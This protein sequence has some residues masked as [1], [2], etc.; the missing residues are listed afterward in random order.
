ME[1]IISGI[2]QMGIGIPNVEEAWAWYRENFMFDV[3]VFDDAGI[4]DLM[5]PYTGN[6]PHERRAILALNLQGGGGFEIWQYVSRK[7]EAPKFQVQLGDYGI[8]IAKIKT[9]NASAAFLKMKAKKLNLLSELV[10]DPGGNNTF[11]VSDPY[12]N[13]FQ[14]VENKNLFVDTKEVN[15][16]VFGAVLGVADIEKSKAFYKEILGYDQLVFETEGQFA[17]FAQIDG[18]K[19]QF[20]RV[21]LRHSKAR[22]GAFAE[23]LGPSE[24]ELLEVTNR[25]AQKIYKERF[26]GDLGYIHLCYDIYG[27]Q[28][29]KKKCEDFG[30]PFTVDSAD[31]FDMGE[32][33]GHFTYIEDPDG[34]LIEF[35]ETHK[36]P[37]VKKMKINLNLNRFN[38]SKSLPKWMLKLAFKRSK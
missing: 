29:L 11:Y 31:S 26:W 37:I 35:V 16:G 12:G 25:K 4:A 22:Q 30:Q 2:Q 14:F 36:I 21:L 19:H 5:L 8:A 15:G 3:K 13:V 38:R 9:S 24:I 28:A 34:T 7:P 20:K 33:A 6:M 10:Q 23:L 32:A 27:M 1:P 17:E 18:G